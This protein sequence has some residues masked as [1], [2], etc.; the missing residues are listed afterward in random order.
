MKTDAILTSLDGQWTGSRGSSQRWQ[1][2]RGNEL[3]WRFKTK[4]EL[5]TFLRAIDE[6]RD[7]LAE[8]PGLLTDQPHPKIPTMTA[9]DYVEF[10]FDNATS[11]RGVKKAMVLICMAIAYPSVP[12]APDNVIPVD[13]AR[14]QRGAA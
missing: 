10:L 14:G 4:G 7:L 5:Q 3:I 1:L 2:R 12:T 6:A 11:Y 13:F 8:N 9:R